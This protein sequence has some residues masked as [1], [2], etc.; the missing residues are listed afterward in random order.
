MDIIFVWLVNQILYRINK[1]KY[2]LQIQT[3]YYQWNS[4]ALSTLASNCDLAIIPLKENNKF[5]L[6]KPENKLILLWKLGLPVF[7]SYS[8]A[9][10]LTMKK[11]KINM[12][13]ESKKDW[14]NSL[15]SFSELTQAKRTK[16]TNDLMNFAN[17]NYKKKYLIE[18]WSLLFE[19]IL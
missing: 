1:N 10:F 12:I 2:K 13:C 5:I 16:I 4:F 7:T 3:F 17:K 8:D 9:Y 18:K 15:L 11:A 19:S 14:I 6:G